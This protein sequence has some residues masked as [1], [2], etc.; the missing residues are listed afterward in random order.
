MLAVEKSI[1]N[2]RE[3][4]DSYYLR[5]FIKYLKKQDNNADDLSLAL[6]KSIIHSHGY[7]N[8]QNKNQYLPYN[9]VNLRDICNLRIRFTQLSEYPALNNDFLTQTYGDIMRQFTQHPSQCITQVNSIINFINDIHFQYHISLADKY[10]SLA[11]LYLH[12]KM[13]H[14]C[15]FFTQKAI[16]IDALNPNIAQYL[17]INKEALKWQQSLEG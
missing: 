13:Y 15:V 6:Q 16:D 7:I 2:Y 1:N 14:E 9:V 10:F 3:N 8:Q 11:N 12:S 17:S 4:A 5:G